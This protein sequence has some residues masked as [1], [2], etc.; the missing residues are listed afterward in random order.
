MLKWIGAVSFQAEGDETGRFLSLCRSSGL[1]IRQFRKTGSICQGYLSPR[2]YKKASILGKSVGVRLRI[3]QKIG[4]PFLIYR[5]RKRLGLFIGAATAVGILLFLQCF[6]WAIDVSGN[7]QITNTHILAAAEKY[8]LKKGLFLPKAD[9]EQIELNMLSDLPSLSFLSLNRIGSRV[10][11]ELSEESP[12]PFIVP[13][14]DPCNIVAS[15]TAQI[16]K[17][18]VYAGQK[19]IH[20]GDVVYEGDLLV[21]GVVESADGKTTYHHASAK[22]M[23][24]TNFT[25]EFTIALNQE[26][27]SYNGKEKKRCRID[28]CGKKLPLFLATSIKMPYDSKKEMNVLRFFGIPLPIGIETET[29]SFY[30]VQPIRFTE[31]QALE[32]IQKNIEIYEQEELKDAEILSKEV[33]ASLDGDLFRTEVHYQCLEDIAIPQKIEAKVDPSMPR[34]P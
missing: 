6:V 29:L 3:Q 20:L 22:I 27:K 28:I 31:E 9:L 26:E 12:K 10:E 13:G 16:V 7:E 32:L 34:N 23:A 33:S 21:S 25:K 5:Y 2:E 1:T 17:T 19:M 14:D 8:G 30:E 11:I 4:V 24:Q 15:K 18:E